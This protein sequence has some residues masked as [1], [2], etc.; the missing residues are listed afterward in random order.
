MRISLHK[1]NSTV[2]LGLE[3]LARAFLLLIMAVM[4]ALTALTHFSQVIGLSFQTYATVGMC[5]SL[6]VML[7]VLRA[8]VFKKN[9]VFAL[10]LRE[11]IVLAG[12]VCAGG[13]LAPLCY[14]PDMD[15][16]AYVPNVV[17]YLAYPDEPM[18]F[19]VHCV[20]TGT[21][22]K[23]TSYFW[24]TSMP[25]EYM[26]GIVAYFLSVHFLSVY[27]LLAPALFGLMIPLVWFYVLSRFSFSTMASIVGAAFICLSLLLVGEQHR[28]F[29]NLAFN[30]IFQGKAVLLS[31]G[32]PLFS[33][34]TIDYFRAPTM[35]RWV[36]VFA[37]SVAMVGATAC[38]V[39]LLTLLSVSLAAA[40]SISYVSK[41][42]AAL[43]R[44]TTYFG[45]MLYVAGYAISILIANIVPFGVEGVVNRGW[46]TTF[47][48]H[49]CHVLG[50][51]VVCIL[52]TLGTAGALIFLRGRERRFL[53]TWIVSCILLYLNPLVCG[54]LIQYVT[55]PNIYWRLFYLYPFPLVLG[56]CAAHLASRWD[57]GRARRGNLIAVLIVIIL[58]ILHFLGF[59]SS[60][61][62]RS[63]TEIRGFTYK[64]DPMELDMARRVAG[65]AP[66]GTM[67]A[68]PE[69]SLVMPMIEG[70]H[71]QML[72]R[73]RATIV[74]MDLCGMS[75]EGHL[76]IRAAYFLGG[77]SKKGLD[78][79]LWLV[80]NYRQIQSVVAHTRVAHENDL[81]NLLGS[82]GFSEPIETD[83]VIVFSK[84]PQHVAE[85]M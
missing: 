40:C 81:Y 5:L 48:P 79:L 82:E 41:M 85:G 73:E 23:C 8:E 42:G 80:R 54:I 66:P 56:L 63:K 4:A 19:G 36:Y 52:M 47:L 43:F 37:T 32:I 7:M 9:A 72:T 77:H 65:I 53:V 46:P 10:R 49:A 31:L 15:D 14:R 29:G 16:A 27:Y 25:F 76:R 51:P 24:Y 75:G 17:H 57:I 78:E 12:I 67:L 83:G 26:Q 50:G 20:D 64:I 71:P 44:A 74:W 1:S 45:S 2:E 70:K 34:L 35:R 55:S 13:L 28:S 11:V 21:D 62:Y 38:S 58:I 6:I 61:F 60:V 3:S 22:D 59:S 18:G 84:R 69:L 33:A 39:V 68:T 30:R